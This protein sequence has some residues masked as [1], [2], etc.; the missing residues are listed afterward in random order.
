MSRDAWIAAAA[1]AA[2]DPVVQYHSPEL[3]PSIHRH[4]PHELRSTVWRDGKKIKVYD[5]ECGGEVEVA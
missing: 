2:L 1:E 3:Q 4:M 5:C